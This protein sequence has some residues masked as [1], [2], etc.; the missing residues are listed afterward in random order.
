MVIFV[1]EDMLLP[2]FFYAPELN[3]TRGQSYIFSVLGYADME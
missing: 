1:L 3:N 2:S